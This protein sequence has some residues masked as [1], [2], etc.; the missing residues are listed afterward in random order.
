[1]VPKEPSLNITHNLLQEAIEDLDPIKNV[2]DLAASAA[3]ILAESDLSTSWDDIVLMLDSEDI[4]ER[5][6]LA[7]HLIFRA[8]LILE[9]MERN[10]RVNNIVYNTMLMM[11]ALEVA[12]IKGY[13]PQNLKLKPSSINAALKKEKIVHTIKEL[14]MENPNKGITW[15]RKKAS[16][17]L[18]EEGLKGYS[19][20][21]IMRDTKGLK[22]T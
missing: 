3:E 17:L 12:N 20:R 10:P 19:Y 11:D 22:I 9:E 6:R 7:A 15:L 1:M 5:L 14:S 2:K 18:T 8:K 16:Q 21:Q 13:L 4:S